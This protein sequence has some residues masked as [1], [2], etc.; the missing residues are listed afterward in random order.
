MSKSKRNALAVAG[1]SVRTPSLDFD[2]LAAVEENSYFL[3]I[4]PCGGEK[5]FGVKPDNI[6]V[7]LV[8]IK[9]ELE[10]TRTR[11]VLHTHANGY[12]YVAIRP[13]GRGWALCDFSHDKWSCWHRPL[14]KVAR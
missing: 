10:Y 5:R 2:W 14:S 13:K 11:S 3:H 7:L 8:V 1:D 6:P 12:D 4:L 9:D